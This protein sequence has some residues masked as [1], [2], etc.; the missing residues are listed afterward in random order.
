M[1]LWRSEKIIDLVVIDLVKRELELDA[2]IVTL[3]L[4]VGEDA[5][6]CAR[7]DAA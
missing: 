6:N 7:K 1:S 4:T 2:V 5:L 3:L